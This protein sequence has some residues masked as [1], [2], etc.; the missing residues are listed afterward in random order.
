MRTQLSIYSKCNP[1]LV[2]VFQSAGPANLMC[3]ALDYAKHKHT[4]LL[5]NGA[6]DILKTAFAVE[7]TIAGATHLV[8]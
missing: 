2:A 7:N 5:C 1:R 3:V 8:E 4:A 6:G